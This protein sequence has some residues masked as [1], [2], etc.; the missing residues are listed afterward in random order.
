MI[1][2]S[3]LKIFQTW[4]FKKCLELE[5]QEKYLSAKIGTHT[6]LLELEAVFMKPLPVYVQPS[7]ENLE[8]EVKKHFDY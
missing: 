8:Q 2:L 3:Q 6:C 5:I 7:I 4:P 1:Q